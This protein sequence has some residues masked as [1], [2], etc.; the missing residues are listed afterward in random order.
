MSPK[1]LKHMRPPPMRN[2]QP[3]SQMSVV[4]LPKV[5]QHIVTISNDIFYCPFCM[6]IV[7]GSNVKY[8]PPVRNC[9][10]TLTFTGP[11]D[12]LCG[13]SKTSSC[14]YFCNNGKYFAFFSLPKKSS[15]PFLQLAMWR[16]KHFP[17]FTGSPTPQAVFFFQWFSWECAL[18]N[19][20]AKCKF[21]GIAVKTQERVPPRAKSLKSSQIFGAAEENLACCSIL[22][23]WEQKTFHKR[24]LCDKQR[25][26]DDSNCKEES[27]KSWRSLRWSHF[28]QKKLTRAI[29]SSPHFSSHQNL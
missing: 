26:C 13:T 23:Q 11:P 19:I 20:L 3:F 25:F 22:Q 24:N 17:F 9:E 14:G 7:Y 15:F 5:A 10:T 18:S 6:F 8:S 4:F 28:H 2:C 21:S 12:V 29:K 27:I 16:R 1:W